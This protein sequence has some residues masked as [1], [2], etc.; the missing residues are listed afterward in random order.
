MRHV[1][2]IT[3]FTREEI[4]DEVLPGCQAQ[5]AVAKKRQAGK[6][7]WPQKK[8][9]KA[10]FLFLEPSTRTKG[11]YG[12]AARLLGWSWNEIIGIEAT[13]L[14]KKESLANTARMLAG[15]GAGVLVI[16][17][18]IE[19]A[20][21]FIAEI[22]EKEG[23]PISIQNGGD[24]TNQ[25]PT[26]TF[27]DLLTI[28]EKLGRL[29]NFKIGFFGDLKYG[30]TVHSLICALAH[31]Q[32]VSL[33]LASD[34]ETTLPDHYKKFFSR[35]EE[36]DDL[37]LLSDCDIIYG[38]RLQEERFLG[39][40][41]ALERA[42][43]RFRLTD[44]I[45]KQFKNSV[46]IM[47]PMPFVNEFAVD[48]RRDPRLIVDEQ[49]WFGVPTRM[50]L[51]QTGYENRGKITALSAKAQSNNRRIL[52]N[53]ALTEY[54]SERERRKGRHQFFRPITDEGVVIDHIPKGLGLI[55][56][57]YLLGQGLISGGVRHLIEE[58]PSISYGFKD[59]LV[60]PGSSISDE[61]MGAISSLAPQVTFNCIRD[62]EFRKIKINTPGIIRGIGACPN[63][64][65]ITNHDPEADVKFINQN[66]GSLTC[67]YCE[68]EFRLKE[69]F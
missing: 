61:A 68:K 42:R 29:S 67:W 47:H 14:T 69:I 41:V 10:T 3:D 16:R 25:H 6:R 62:G 2:S 17:A 46:L 24:G 13:S 53:I 58:V 43:S 11:S 5:I 8:N 21:K 50:Y 60:L 66:N 56:R 49:A 35:A 33:T 23:Y 31:C 28:S 4:F 36:G 9:R 34:P 59:V 15:Q 27:L 7:A 37:G 57:E 40:Q 65:C 19:G 55:I 52:K 44:H 54:L 48:I 20:Q 39:D 26:Q 38:S 12:E 18:K 30:R 45:L 22:L 32:D 63:P 1:I 51:L 64:N